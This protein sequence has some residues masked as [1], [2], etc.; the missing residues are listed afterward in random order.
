RVLHGGGRRGH[1]RLR[2]R[3]LRRLDGRA[4]PQ[5]PRPVAGA[6]PRRPGLLAGGG[7][8]RRLRLRGRV[9][10]VDGRAP[11]QRPGDRHGALRR[12]L[13]DGGG[14]RRR[15]RLLVAAVLGLPRSPSAGP[16]GGGGGR[17][18]AV[19]GVPT[20]AK[21]TQVRPGVSL[22]AW[23]AASVNR[24]GDDAESLDQ[25]PLVIR[26]LDRIQASPVPV[27]VD[28]TTLVPDWST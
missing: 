22:T 19:T 5:R 14:R 9:P 23:P 1:L 11:A 26:P 25:W 4:A 7:R 20:G 17:Y 15:L 13:P 16:P 28:S 2:R 3:R 18:P 12:R 24:V 10:G 8:R 27:T 6:G 21:L